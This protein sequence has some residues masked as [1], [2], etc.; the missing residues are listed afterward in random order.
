LGFQVN[1]AIGFLVALAVISHDFTDGMNTVALM[2]LHKNN[3]RKTKIF[4]LA[5]A[6]SPFWERIQLC[7]LRFRRNFW[8]CIWD[9]SE[10]FWFI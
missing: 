1:S 3:S 4:L 2:L 10:G 7:Y 8:L 9:F 5:D 6:F